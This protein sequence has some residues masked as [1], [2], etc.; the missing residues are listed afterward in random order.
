MI[1][2]RAMVKYVMGP[3]PLK[4]S[5]CGRWP[6]RTRQPPS[7]C[8]RESATQRMD[9]MGCGEYLEGYYED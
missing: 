6:F 9:A 5:T 8:E 1:I 7:R 3:M 2:P 4:K